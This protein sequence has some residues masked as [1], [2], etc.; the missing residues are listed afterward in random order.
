MRLMIVVAVSIA[1]MA[2]TA[3]ASP[4]SQ[5]LTN[6]FNKSDPINQ[7]Y[8][9]GNLGYRNGSVQTSKLNPNGSTHTTIYNSTE[10]MRYS[11]DRLPNGTFSGGHWNMQG[12]YYPGLPKNGS[13]N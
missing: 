8:P 3:L 2:G 9:N 12:G 5:T 7:I 4:K 1:L 10:G 13:P 6:T 11:Y